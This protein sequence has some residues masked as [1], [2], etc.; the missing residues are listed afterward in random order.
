M[1]T[2]YGWYAPVTGTIAYVPG[3]IAATAGNQAISFAAGAGLTLE[4]FPPPDEEAE[5]FLGSLG[6]AVGADFTWEMWLRTT[7][8]PGAAL[9]LL[10]QAS[11]GVF[12]YRL[13]L[14]PG[15]TLR[16]SRSDGTLTATVDSV[17]VVNDDVWHYVTA[18]KAGAVFG[19]SVDANTPATTTDTLVGST[20]LAVD[21][22]V[23]GDGFAG[24]IGELAL[25]PTALSATQRARHLAAA[26]GTPV[27][28]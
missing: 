11:A 25:Y 10:E 4:Y 21:G 13:E 23:A 19:L 2:F 28:A 15:G 3:P 24:A 26:A 9:R 1:T 12:P 16:A 17:Q 8:L 6:R 22:T 20:T 5:W 7:Q 18:Y 14:L 27:A